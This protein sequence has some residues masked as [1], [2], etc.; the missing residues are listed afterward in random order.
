MRRP[1]NVV[2]D[3]IPPPPKNITIKMLRILLDSH[4]SKSLPLI[5]L[6][7]IKIKVNTLQLN[8]IVKEANLL[9]CVWEFSHLLER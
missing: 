4:I 8:F 1:K 7:I 5:L 2:E 9:H 6:T 3:F